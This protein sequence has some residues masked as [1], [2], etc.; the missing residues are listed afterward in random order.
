VKVAFVTARMPYPPNI[1]G[2]IRTFHLLKEVSKAHQVTL[3]TALEGQDDERALANIQEHIPGMTVRVVNVPSRTAPFRRLVR[4]AR[5]PIDPLPYTWA[6]YRHPR[7]TTN[8]LSAL[9]GN[10]YDFVHCDHVQ[11]AYPLLGLETPPR[12]INAHNV[13]SLLIRRLAE[14]ELRRWR[15]ALITWQAYKTLQAEVRTYRSFHRCA[16]VS[17]VDRAHIEK[18]APGL[19]ISIVPNGVDVDWFEPRS[20]TS[21]PHLMVFTGAMDWLPNIDSVS[22]FVKEVFPRIKK[23]VPRAQL[24]VV[25][26]HP[27]ESL[28]RRLA[29]DGI[30]FTG[31]V[32]DVR[33]H[34]AQARLVVV[35]LRIGAGTRLKILEAWAMGKAVLSTSIGAEGL[36]AVDGENI[37]IADTAESLA[38][39]AVALLDDAKAVARLGA[40]GRCIAEERFAWRRVAAA[41]LRAYEETVSGARHP[42][43]EAV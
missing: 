28:L 6:G 17:E 8:L 27:S 4:A 3:I 36:P 20:G 11:V 7:F 15:K 19:P 33:P 29:G 31:T 16:A 12:L 2:R 14:Q 32:D 25:G 43:M 5:S 38:E 24:R 41:L 23:S 39:R 18:M 40:V 42:S 1:G 34:L 30:R 9:R 35:P 21:D 13:E 22:F 37:A 26:R 10:Y